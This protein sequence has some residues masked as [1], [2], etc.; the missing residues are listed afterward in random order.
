MNRRRL[1]QLQS[2]YTHILEYKPRL[3]ILLLEPDYR[4]DIGMF[5]F[6][7]YL[8]LSPSNRMIIFHNFYSAGSAVREQHT[9]EH[10]TEITTSN[11]ILNLI[12]F[13]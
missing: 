7:Q 1:I 2:I 12:F 8:R 10:I 3:I 9:L 4:D 6:F 11:G 13:H 5:K